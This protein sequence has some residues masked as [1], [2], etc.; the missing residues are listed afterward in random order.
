MDQAAHLNGVLPSSGPE[1]RDSR[2]VQRATGNGTDGRDTPA[3]DPVAELEHQIR[4]GSFFLQASLEQHG[5]L[6]S[7]LDAFLTALIDVLI[8]SDVVD[9]DRLGAV[10][11]ANR[12][13]QAEEKAA[14]LQD[15]SGLGS[16]PSVV[17]REEKPDEPDEPDVPVDCAARLPICKAACC[18]LRFPLSPSEVEQGTA[19]WDIGHPYLIRHTSEGFCVH[20]DRATGGCKIYDQRPGVCRRYSCAGDTRIWKDFD[21]MVLN[22]EYLASRIPHRFHLRPVDAEAVPV[23]V[24]LNNATDA[25]TGDPGGAGN[26]G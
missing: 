17:V 1:G 5:Q 23:T 8:E 22:E 24:S 14:E 25:T 3:D 4:Q 7:R 20:N 12:R 26:E 11:A 9:V 15:G 16:W 10:V 2:A 13:Q 6:T 18:S 21:N 19:K